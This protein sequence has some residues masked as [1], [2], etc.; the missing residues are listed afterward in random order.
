HGGWIQTY[1]APGTPGVTNSQGLNVYQWMAQ[2][3]RVGNNVVLDA[4]APLPVTWGPYQAVLT[5]SSLVQVNWSTL[6]EQNN[7][8]FIVQRSGDGRQFSNLDTIPAAN[9]PHSYSYLDAAPI[10]GTAYYRLAQVDLD[11]KSSYSGVMPVYLSSGGRMALRLT[12]NPAP[13]TIYLELQNAEQGRLDV[14]LTD[15][16]GKVLRKWTFDKQG[17]RW[18]QWVDPGN[19][20]A[21]AYFITVKGAKTREVRSFIRSKQ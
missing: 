9:Q 1:G 21:G 17:Q 2:F 18:S 12:P 8:Y 20:P 11:G 19:L 3:K 10:T 5:D 14:S 7:R 6:L 13:G 16:T 15:V 4:A